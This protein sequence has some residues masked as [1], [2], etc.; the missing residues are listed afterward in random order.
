L[1]IRDTTLDK[2]PSDQCH[3]DNQ[4]LHINKLNVVME[5]AGAETGL[6]G[7]HI[8]AILSDELQSK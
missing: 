1:D 2:I 5:D 7:D 6:T 3:G 4:L 8:W